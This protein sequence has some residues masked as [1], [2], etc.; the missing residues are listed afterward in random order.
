MW[1]VF[2]LFWSHFFRRWQGQFLCL[3]ERLL[4]HW[5]LLSQSELDHWAGMW[6]CRSSADYF[7]HSDCLRL[8][9]ETQCRWR[10]RETQNNVRFEFS[11][12]CE[13][14]NQVSRL[15]RA[16]QTSFWINQLF[17]KFESLYLKI[18]TD[19]WKFAD[20]LTVLVL[21]IDI[22]PE[23]WHWCSYSSIAAA[24]IMCTIWCFSNSSEVQS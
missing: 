20:R 24:Y 15:R 21:I 16:I 3:S 11:V 17:D 7:H 23:L 1:F 5:R 18:V 8:S 13:R 12:V 14:C 6:I 10:R 19:Q 9:E 4:K 2:R 22:S